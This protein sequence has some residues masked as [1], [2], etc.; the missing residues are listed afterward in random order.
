MREYD[1]RGTFGRTLFPADAY[2]LG[3]RFAAL[4]RGATPWG[5][6]AAS[7]PSEARPRVV[8]GRDGR[9]SSPDLEAALVDGL[10]RGGVDVIRIGLGP[11]PMLYFAE[12]SLEEVEGGIQVTGSHN[13]ADDNGFKIVLRG[14]AL[15]GEALNRLCTQPYPGGAACDEAI[16]TNLAEA[17]GAVGT[18]APSAFESSAFE[19]GAIA[20]GEVEER[21]LAG[22]YVRVLLGALDGIE[23]G[24]LG[25]MALGWDAGNGAAGP[26]VERLCEGLAGKHHV[27]FS[28]VD[29]RFPNHHPDPT[30]AENLADLRGLVAAKNLDFGVAFDGDGDRI[31]VIDGAGRVLWADQLLALFA[32]EVL[33][34]FPEAGVVADVKMSA[35][36]FDAVRTAGGRAIMAPSGHSHIKSTMKASGALLGGEMSGHLF[37]ADRYFGYDDGLYAALR[38]IALVARAGVSLA[39]LHDRL[40]VTFATPEMRFP[41]APERR[42]AVVAEIGARLAQ[43]GREVVAIDGLRVAGEEGWWLLRASNTQ[44][45]LTARAEAASEAGCDRLLA[46]IDAQLRLSGVTRG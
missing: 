11:S 33:G 29:G 46:E 44:D 7:W 14:R 40:P 16:A 28:E 2:A 20:P 15:F 30:I 43:A 9:L 5:P 25:Q 32:D 23:P 4:V 27:L 17:A 8:V 22:A 36:V 31:G 37:F 42:L 6:S 24:A 41:V 3:L 19:S 35:A 10:I 26:I 45:M 38:L 1:L 34:V 12:A 21:D 13:P 18:F 39:A